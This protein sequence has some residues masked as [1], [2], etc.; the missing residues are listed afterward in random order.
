MIPDSELDAMLHR[1]EA[2]CQDRDREHRRDEA[3]QIA[4]YVPRLVAEVR[5]MKVEIEYLMEDRSRG[6]FDD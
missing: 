5:M 3:E 2:M 6:M 4:D 1:H